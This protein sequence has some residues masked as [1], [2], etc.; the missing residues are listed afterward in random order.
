MESSIVIIGGGFGGIKAAKILGQSKDVSVTLLDR[1][2][3][4]LFQPLLYQV[5]TAALNPSDIGVPIRLIL[6]DCLN[7]R[8]HMENVLSVDLVANKVITDSDTHAFDYLIMAC[9]SSHSYF[10]H[11][12]WEEFAPGLKTIEHALEI[13]RRILLAFEKAEK[14]SD[15]AI[16]AKLLTFVVVGGGPTGVELAGSVAELA[17][18]IVSKEFRNIQP[19]M[20]RII[21]VQG[22]ERLLP[23]FASQLS[24]NA[25]AVLESKGVEVVLK[26]HADTITKEGITVAGKF[27]PTATIMW[28]AGVR[29]SPLNKFLGAQLD[30]E[31]RVIVSQDLSVPGH[32]NVFVVGD[33]AR[34]DS[35]TGPLP[36]LAPVAMQ[37][38]IVA[39]AN[40]LRDLSGRPRKPF[41]F[42]NKGTMAVIG[43]AY[44]VVELP[45]GKSPMARMSGFLAWVIWIFV[46]IMY[47]V[48]Y[49]NRTIVLLTWAW[50]YFTFKRGARMITQRVWKNSDVP[51]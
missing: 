7:T 49:R 6:A 23:T 31:G 18:S 34:F 21:L 25:K 46:H 32:P 4:H 12:E 51:D 35:P 28:A 13:R 17:N 48:G 27:I 3:H 37:Q 14:E 40:I 10:G 45:M 29:P 22:G 50:S 44:A 43:R 26:Q 33:Q 1:K 39:A 41:H 42:I 16:Q 15:P 9:G 24:A 19:N 36:G 20:T 2:N 11:D 8:V 38:G 47:L 30:K 5:A